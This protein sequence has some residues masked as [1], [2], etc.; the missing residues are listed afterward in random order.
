MHPGKAGHKDRHKTLIS[1]P[2]FLLLW[3][4]LPIWYVWECLLCGPFFPMDQKSVDLF[5][6]V[7]N[8]SVAVFS[9]SRPFYCGPLVHVCRND[10][11]MMTMM[12]RTTFC[13]WH[14]MWL[15]DVFFWSCFFR[16]F[17]RDKLFY[18]DISV[19]RECPHF[20]FVRCSSSL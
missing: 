12:I 9:V 7:S 20:D 4:F 13:V 3:T 6:P 1:G 14:H 8:F 17:L 11:M 16:F 10:I 18:D 2:F 15:P 19:C 5:L